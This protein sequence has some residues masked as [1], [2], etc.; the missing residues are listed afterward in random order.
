MTGGALPA[1]EFSRIV[2]VG[3]LGDHPHTREIAATPAERAA[4][5]ER[6]GL[7][8]LSK[9]SAT[10]TL[11]RR[12]NRVVELRGHYEAELEQI[13]VV[14]LEPVPAH[15]ARSFRQIYSA[16]LP[17]EAVGEVV[18]DADDEE[19]EAPEPLIGNQIDLGEAVAQQLAVA[20]DP[21]PR[22]PEAQLPEAYAKAPEPPEQGGAFA[23]L[24]QLLKS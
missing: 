12:G 13:C 5:A 23:T 21:Y 16:D 24:A 18:V 11:H 15:I 8:S 3:G 19:D 2:D 17:A 14:S 10:L 1:P 22:R 20:L 7:H 6:F 9:L 4:L